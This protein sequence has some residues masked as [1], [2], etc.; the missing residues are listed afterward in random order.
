MRW[1]AELALGAVAVTVCMMGSAWAD[2]ARLVGSYTWE[3]DDDRF[4]GWSG[5]E[6]SAD[7]SGMVV[8]SDR[9]HIL[10]AQ[11]VRK[12]GRIVDVLDDG[13]V[14]LRGIKGEIQAHHRGDAEGL[15]IRPDGRRFVS[16]EGFHRVWAYLTPDA[17]AWL[18]RADGFKSLQ[19]NSSLEALAI[20][21]RGW[22]YT[23]PER[24]GGTEIPFPVFR[25]RDGDWDQPFSIPRDDGFLMAGADFGPDGRLYVLERD[26]TGFG[27]RSQVRSFDIS[28]GTAADEKVHLTSRVRAHDNLEG[29]AVWQDNQGFIRLTMISDDNFRFIQTTEIVEYTL[30]PSPKTN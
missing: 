29:L 16:Y 2:S 1:R 27:F 14:P 28:S 18:P 13:I 4:G 15:A 19:S 23:M 6:L 9:G 21:D 22:L 5:L 10:D 7:G 25:Y 17:A 3:M 30:A 11:L 8:I 24:S 20:D 26:F 12:D